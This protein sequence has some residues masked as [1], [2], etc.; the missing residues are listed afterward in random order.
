MKH[1]VDRTAPFLDMMAEAGEIF[2]VE[3]QQRPKQGHKSVLY[4]HCDGRTI[5]RISHIDN[6]IMPEDDANED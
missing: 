6:L 5:V 2:T 1:S 3:V 4:I